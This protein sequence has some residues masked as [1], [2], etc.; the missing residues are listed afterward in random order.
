MPILAR[1]KS[2][3]SSSIAFNNPCSQVMKKFS[4]RVHFLAAQIMLLCMWGCTSEQALEVYPVKGQV[5]FQSQPAA[6]AMVILQPSSD[7]DNH[8]AFARLGFPHAQ[9][10]NDGTFQM[11]T[12]AWND[13]AP[14]GNYVVSVTW[15][16]MGPH[17]DPERTQLVEVHPD[18]LQGAFAN[19]TDPKFKVTIQKQP[20]EIPKLELSSTGS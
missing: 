4:I 15:P 8:P 6:G 17:Q 3:F 7:L 13:G 10:E 20:T 18:R 9:V 14:P 19:P 2:T 11:T 16:V 1:S 5:Y 12:Y